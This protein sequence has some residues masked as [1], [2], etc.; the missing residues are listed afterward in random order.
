MNINCYKIIDND[1]DIIP[2]VDCE[3]KYLILYLLHIE[4][5]IRYPILS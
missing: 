3:F 2:F 4:Y 1:Y 5:G